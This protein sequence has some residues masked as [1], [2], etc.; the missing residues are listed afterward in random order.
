MARLGPPVLVGLALASLVGVITWLSS[1]LGDDLGRASG[2]VVE[3]LPA[4]AAGRV[5]GTLQVLDAPPAVS[6]SSPERRV[7]E[8]AADGE[9]V[10]AEAMLEEAMIGEALLAEPGRE[11]DGSGMSR[12]ERLQVLLRAYEGYL[13]FTD[14]GPV[15]DTFVPR[16][17]AMAE[18]SLASRCIATILRAEGRADYGDPDELAARGGFSLR[19]SSPEEHVFAA[20][21]ARFAF[22]KGEFPAYDRATERVRSAYFDETLPPLTAPESQ[23]LDQLY[24]RALGVLGTPARSPR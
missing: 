11:Q 7:P 13:R 16:G 18:R 20:D 15:P 3:A 19:S 10:G 5:E 23:E 6:P 9:P 8:R 4:G 24:A 22:F 17:R 12:E 14:T 21:R 1:V 2:R